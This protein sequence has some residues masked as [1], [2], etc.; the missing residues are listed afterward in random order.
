MINNYNYWY[1]EKAISNENCKKIIDLAKIKNSKK[2]GTVGNLETV[3]NKKNKKFKEL[4]KIRHSDV[5]WL[6]EK[7]IYDLIVPYVQAANCNSG[8]NYDFFRWESA[9]FT[10]YKKNQYYHWHADTTTE[11]SLE[12]NANKGTLRK[13][14]MSLQLSDE[15][16]YKG[17]DLQFD[18]KDVKKKNTIITD[19][20]LRQ[21]GT[22]VVFPSYIWHRVTPVTKGT[23]Y[24]LVLWNLG[25]PFR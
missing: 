25:Y 23:R 10:I 24:S 19:K 18:I 4:K 14:S 15:K 7:F 16:D 3:E 8:W 12:E 22:I 21:K 17:G 20:K 2:I 9:Q 13:L 1:F 5:V 11:A 6:D